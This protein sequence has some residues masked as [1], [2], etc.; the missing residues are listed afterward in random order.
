MPRQC[1]RVEQFGGSAAD[2]TWCMTGGERQMRVHYL[3]CRLVRLDASTATLACGLGVRS[4]TLY[5]MATLRGCIH[6]L[7]TRWKGS[8]MRE[9]R[10]ILLFGQ[11]RFS[12][13]GL[14]PTDI[15][16]LSGHKPEATKRI[17][18]GK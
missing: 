11:V 8:D 9:L 10:S 4:I 12:S 2:R 3:S 18:S 7:C 14:Q 6:A 16:A 1:V 17:A 5:G 13:S 15:P